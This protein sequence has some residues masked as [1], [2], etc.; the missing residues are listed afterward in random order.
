MNPD[1][2][3]IAT[4]RLQLGN[5]LGFREAALLLEHLAALGISHIYTSPVLDAVPGSTHG[6]DVVDH[7][8]PNDELGGEDGFR[9]LVSAAHE[10][11]IG[12]VL[13][14]VPNH[15][16]THPHNSR[17]WDVLRFGRSSAYES[18]FDIDWE[19]GTEATPDRLLLAVLADHYGASVR[20]GQVT[21]DILHD[22]LVVRFADR[23]FPL[24][25]A[26]VVE[27]LRDIAVT[28]T[29]A[30]TTTAT[31]TSTFLAEI[32]EL[33]HSGDS[34]ADHSDAL[35]RLSLMSRF[36]QG[37]RYPAFQ[38][39]LARWNSDPERLHGVLEQ[40]HYRLAH[41]STGT[42]SL[43]YRRF[44]DVSELIGL[45]VEDDAVFQSVHSRTLQWVANG[46]IDGLRIDHP[47]GLADPT[48]YLQTLRSQAPDAWIV[49]EKILADGESLPD[50]WPVDGTT[51][52]ES[53]DLLDRLFVDPAGEPAM[54]AVFEAST[55][56]A[57]D[58]PAIR[59][60]AKE[61]VLHQLLL[62]E[63]HR[64]RHDLTEHG[65]GMLDRVDMSAYDAGAAISAFLVEMP[66]Y[67]TYAQGSLRAD[68]RDVAII[69]GLRAAVHARG[70]FDPA[71]VDLIANLLVGPHDTETGEQFRLRFQQVSGPVM[72]KGVEDTAFYRFP[73]LISLNEVGGDP[74]LFGIELADF[75]ARQAEAEKRAP[76]R[77]VATSTH[78]TKRSEDVRA[79]IAVLS[80]VPDQWRAAVEVFAARAAALGGDHRDRVLE[81][82]LH[83]TIVGASPITAERMVTNARKAAREAKR[84]T[85]WLQP[86]EAYEQ[87]LAESVTA[88]LEDADYVA[89]LRDLLDVIVL[90]GRV[91]GL[92]E[93][94]LALTIPGVPD[95]Y[96]GSEWWTRDL[97]DPDNR[98]PVDFDARAEMLRTLG[99]GPVLDLTDDGTAKL[100]VVRAA[101]QLRRR[102]PAAFGPGTG[103][104]EPLVA[105][106]PA[107]EHVVGFVRGDAVATIVPRLLL[108]LQAAGGWRATRLELPAGR[109]SDVISGRGFDGSVAV[110]E[111][112][113]PNPVALL[114]RT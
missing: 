107:S 48:T 73:R 29:T 53:L 111:L 92:A 12:L 71:I 14:I 46:D 26:S 113:S 16:A 65:R 104:Y 85:S 74:T 80:E 25:M 20:D 17:W 6:Y 21:L 99:D 15:M 61:D 66:V 50:S 103:S 93:K 108:R 64:L 89:A 22:S 87:H 27:I 4:Y 39:G 52:Y 69:E 5:G 55:G 44:F 102:H 110:A 32:D 75:H 79:R 1:R 86:D 49:V 77:M 112:F 94:L 114:E 70:T 82:L 33:A 18:W 23:V 68:D 8:L 11:G 59:R 9:Q 72:A 3:L 96:Q 56:E 35:R 34:V 10:H 97:V 98:R 30:E 76:M 42:E 78:D 38:A 36:W 2:P 106:G 60:A 90:P 19:H 37:D 100:R 101:L 84:R 45:R 58:F 24:C 54:S 67:R 41:W 63:V 28:D 7:H 88:W 40:Q 81:Y 13:D 57:D 51:G 83:Q 109:W 47:D 62:A 91:N 43:D 31:D 105:D 95:L